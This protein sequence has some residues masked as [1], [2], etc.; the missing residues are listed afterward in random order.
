M[1]LYTKQAAMMCQ[2]IKDMAKSDF[3]LDN[4][5]SY[6]SHHFDSWMKKFAN[7]P[8]DLAAE[9]KDFASITGYEE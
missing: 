2:A 1:D 6:L 3:A 5:E 9:L 8:D 4:F 7:T